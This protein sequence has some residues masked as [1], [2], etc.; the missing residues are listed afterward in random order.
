MYICAKTQALTAFTVCVRVCACTNA[1]DLSV[2]L[3]LKRIGENKGNIFLLNK[4][5]PSIVVRSEAEAC[6]EH[7]STPLTQHSIGPVLFCQ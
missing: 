1:V 2:H 7:G 4:G 5:S 6:H 3:D